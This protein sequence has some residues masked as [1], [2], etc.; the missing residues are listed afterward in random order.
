MMKWNATLKW[1][2][3][4]ISR[5]NI[6]L[7]ATKINTENIFSLSQNALWSEDDIQGNF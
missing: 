6:G 1:V 5:E 4:L 2:S 3:Q 7:E